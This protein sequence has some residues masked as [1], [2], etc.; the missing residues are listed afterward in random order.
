MGQF[1][2]VSFVHRLP[3]PSGGSFGTFEHKKYVIV[4]FVNN[5]LE[6]HKRSLARD[7]INIGGYQNYSGYGKSSH[8]VLWETQ[9]E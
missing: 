7:R 4:C 6:L 5:A 3:L 9:I 2:S 1:S 8:V